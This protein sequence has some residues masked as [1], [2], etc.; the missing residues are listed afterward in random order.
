M[1]K[2]ERWLGKETVTLLAASAALFA[3]VVWCAFSR[4]AERTVGQ[5]L[6]RAG[7]PRSVDIPELW[8]PPGPIPKVYLAGRRPNP[9]LP[10]EEGM[11]ELDIPLDVEDA[12]QTGGGTREDD[13]V[14]FAGGGGDKPTDDQAQRRAYVAKASYGVTGGRRLGLL[15]SEKGDYF[16]VCEGE[17]VPRLGLNVVRVAGSVIIVENEEGERF[18]HFLKRASGVTE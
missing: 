6:V 18:R 5:V 11:P 1:L 4:P 17:A 9:F 7:R 2:R 10:V 8:A 13:N 15:R 14:E 12:G 3:G 16:V